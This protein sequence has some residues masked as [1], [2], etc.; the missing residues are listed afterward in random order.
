[1]FLHLPPF[2]ILVEIAMVAEIRFPE[3]RFINVEGRLAI[4]PILVTVA[5]IGNGDAWDWIVKGMLRACRWFNL[6]TNGRTV[7]KGNQFLG[8]RLVSIVLLQH[9]ANAVSI[10]M[11]ID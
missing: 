4:F 10:A 9:L 6:R 2:A 5:H 8:L 11:D 7:S 1:M 3:S